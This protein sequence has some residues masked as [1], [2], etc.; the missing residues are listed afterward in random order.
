MR[1]PAMELHTQE[2]LAILRA[3]DVPAARAKWARDNPGRG[4]PPGPMS[5]EETALVGM[6]KARVQ[7]G[8]MTDEEREHSR[9]WLRDNGH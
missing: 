7:L 5:A 2:L 9:Q 4:M 8:L 1:H 3:L 6:H